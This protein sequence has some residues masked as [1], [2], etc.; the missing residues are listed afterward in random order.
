MLISL[1]NLGNPLLTWK[2]NIYKKKK[3]MVKNSH[4][5][6]NHIQELDDQKNV[7]TKSMIIGNSP[8]KKRQLN[9]K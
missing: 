5:T 9:K 1:G 6:K 3:K 2:T 7:N 8:M 4:Y